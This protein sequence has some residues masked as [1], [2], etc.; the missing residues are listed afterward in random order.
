[1]DRP[2][3]SL[4]ARLHGISL[5][6]YGRLPAR[7]R[8][9]VVRAIAPSFTVGSMCIIER[10]N[11][12]ILFVRLSYRSRWGVPGGL[13]ERGESPEDAARREVAEEVGLDVEL[14]GE[15]AVVVDAT[16]QRVDIVFRARVG[17]DGTETVVA[18]S[19][20]IEE[21]RWF[22]RE[23]L[24]ELQPETVTA[25]IALA[26]AGVPGVA[27]LPRPERWWVSEV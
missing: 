10:D 12:D 26:R 20:E 23:A 1:M 11:G 16:P 13:L 15:P 14:V 8:R 9:L 5:R 21:A 25:I 22:P 6:V 3:D 19:P 7:I 18:R 2:A 4:R 27:D 17:T 24:P